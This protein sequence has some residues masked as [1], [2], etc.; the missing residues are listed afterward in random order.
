MVNYWVLQ[1]SSTC[2]CLQRENAAHLQYGETNVMGIFKS[3]VTTN[4]SVFKEDQVNSS[5]CQSEEF[6]RKNG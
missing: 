6:K 2:Q 3:P 1:I 4:K 5:Y